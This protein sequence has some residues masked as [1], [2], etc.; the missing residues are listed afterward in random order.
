M[1]KP[2]HYIYNKEQS[3]EGKKPLFMLHGYGSNEVDLYMLQ[4]RIPPAY[5]VISLRAPLK[6][7]YGG[8]AW[9]PL[10]TSPDGTLSVKEEEIERAQR[11]LTENL[12]YLHRHFRFNKPAHLLG[13]SQGSIISYILLYRNPEFFK[14]LVAFS[15]YLHEPSLPDS[16]QGETNHLEIFASHGTFDD[17]IP[18]EWARRISPRLSKDKIRHIYKEYP[19]GHY[20][21][22][23]NIQDAMHFLENG[24]Q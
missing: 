14:K 23:E 19:A 15:G 20:L 13:F 7:P 5:F 3:P 22:E 2:L 1:F 4:D 16:P 21:I 17:I 11:I 6:T 18:V 12:Q 10:Y 24:I 9:Y 8:Y